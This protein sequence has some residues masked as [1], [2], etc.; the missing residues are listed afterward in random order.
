[1]QVKL[2]GRILD[3]VGIVSIVGF[4]VALLYNQLVGFGSALR[5]FALSWLFIYVF[6][7]TL[8][9]R[10][11]L[12]AHKDDLRRFSFEWIVA[13]LVGIALMVFVLTIG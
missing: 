9:F 7:A 8:G 3:I 10:G 1:M 12:D 13:C 6:A 5:G 11:N 2:I 4:L